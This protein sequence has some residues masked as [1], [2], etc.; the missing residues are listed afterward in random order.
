MR[1]INTL[2]SKFSGRTRVLRD[3][4]NLPAGIY[5][6]EHDESHICML[7][8]GLT[9]FETDAKDGMKEDWSDSYYKRVTFEEM[10][11]LLLR[12]KP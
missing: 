10:L 5:Y 12:R 4:E 8:S 2:Y 11:S 6:H 3:V 7:H 1:L 9:Y